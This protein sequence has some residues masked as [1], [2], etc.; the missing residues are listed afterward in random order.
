MS[1]NRQLGSHLSRKFKKSIRDK[2]R[3]NGL[4]TNCGDRVEGRLFNRTTG[5]K[6]SMCCLCLRKNAEKLGKYRKERNEKGLCERCGKFAP[7]KGLKNCVLCTKVMSANA[8]KHR[9]ARFFDR[10][11]RTTKNY[12]VGFARQLAFLWKRQKGLCAL[13]GTKLNRQNSE[14]DHIIPKSKSG[15]NEIANLRWVLRDANRAKQAMFDDD[16]ISLCK[17]VVIW[18]GSR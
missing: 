18:A 16:F 4:C 9:H 8:K 2:R 13:T 17:M 15:T 10:K 1:N 7:K 12:S 11:A 6:R 3:E 14:L 5:K